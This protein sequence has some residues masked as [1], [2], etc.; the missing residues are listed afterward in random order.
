MSRIFQLPRQVVIDGGVASGAARANFY[1]TGTTTRTNTYTDAALTTPHANPVIANSAGEFAV[2]YLDSDTVYRLILND[3]V[4]ALIYD[5]DPV[6]DTAPPFFPIIP[7]ETD[8][9]LSES[10]LTTKYEPYDV[11][12][13]PGSDLSVQLSAAAGALSSSGGIIDASN[14]T[15]T[16][17]ISE[18]FFDGIT[19]P[20]H[21]IFGNY[22]VEMDMSSVSL[23]P[24]SNHTIEFRGTTFQ[25]DADGTTSHSVN[26]N[27]FFQTKVHE[28]TGTISAS[29]ASLVVANATGAEVGAL[30][31]IVGVKTAS[32]NQ[33]STLNGAI[34]D[35]V[36]TI[37]VVN[38]LGYIPDTGHIGV[39]L[40]ESELI[41][42]TAVSGNDLTGC[43]RGVYGTS[44]ASHIDTTVVP[45]V[46]K[47]F[48]RIKSVSGTT[49]ILDRT[50]TRAVTSAP[51]DI[52]TVNVQIIGNG[53]L[54]GRQLRGSSN[55]SVNINAI[56]GRVCSR[57]HVDPDIEIYDWDF[58]GVL[59][60]SSWDCTIFA[61]TYYGNGRPA[62]STG[63]AIFIIGDC[64]YNT[65]R[66]GQMRDN[67]FG[68]IVDD[69]SSTL[70]NMWIGQPQLNNAYIG[71]ISGQP[72]GILIGGD[73]NSVIA[74]TVDCDT[75]AIRISQSQSQWTPGNIPT[76]N[77]NVVWV[78]GKARGGSG[79]WVNLQTEAQGGGNV[80]HCGSFV[81]TTTLQTGNSITY[82]YDIAGAT[83]DF[84]Y[85]PVVTAYT[86]TATV[87]E[88]RTLAA[89]ASATA[90]N[91]N[92][93]LAQ[94]LEDLGYV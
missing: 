39:V 2:I 74:E 63:S 53:K 59:L 8:S 33:E 92:A 32:L 52:G 17:T 77:Q 82:F 19:V 13:Y 12:R 56:E 9:G 15:G 71:T 22:T 36:T 88:S 25:P 37:T 42:Y 4:S 66:V 67:V 80:V 51:V 24:Y 60:R 30:V 81:G 57:L 40:I 76:P 14:V 85:L 23:N 7:D 55:P 65:T 43:I 87:V 10:N 29:S 58:A 16:Q 62:D 48:A 44:A 90:A 20:M 70:D 86:R 73:R 54:N 72:F 93:V 41:S 84:K 83:E 3:S 89:N 47:N 79:D 49:I 11:R 94:L 64:R 26:N 6:Q 34:T 21:I 61:Q 1:L 35:S 45:A 75:E 68:Y 46:L 38:S 50:V 78:H 31:A 69:R 5:E 28:T 18:D 91:N 27:G